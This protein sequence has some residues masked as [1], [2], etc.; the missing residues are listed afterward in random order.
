M[1]ANVHKPSGAVKKA[2]NDEV[3]RQI[4]EGVEKLSQ[5]LEAL[6]LWQLHEQLGFG[7]KR[8]L[9]FHKKFAPALAELQN[10]YQMQSQEETD[11][12]V[13]YK[14]KEIGVDIEKLDSA[15]PIRAKINK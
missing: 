4:A 6:V 15:F 12:L 3:N 8:L 5:N 1:R 11:F 13:K 7:K 14:L 2:I 10:F 9:R